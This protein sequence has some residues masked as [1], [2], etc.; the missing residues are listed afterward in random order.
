MFGSD[1]VVDRQTLLHRQCRRVPYIEAVL[2]V[3]QTFEAPPRRKRRHEEE[4]VPMPDLS[5]M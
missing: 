3:P 1:A 4:G 5:R 2:Q